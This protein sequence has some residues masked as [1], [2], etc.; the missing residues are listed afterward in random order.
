MY[1]Y[2]VCMNIHICMC[3]CL[4]SPDHMDP[5]DSMQFLWQVSFFSVRF[6]K[7]NCSVGISTSSGLER[8]TIFCSN[9]ICISLIQSYCYS[10]RYSPQ[11][12]THSE[13]RVPSSALGRTMNSMEAEVQVI[14]SSDGAE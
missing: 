2:N 13:M 4:H 10:K 11:E 5:V 3:M 14:S 1:M 12:T 6:R 9:A 8:K 7:H